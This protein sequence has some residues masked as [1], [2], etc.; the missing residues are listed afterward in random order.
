MK[1]LLKVVTLGMMLAASSTLAFASPLA[2]T[3]TINGATGAITPT[4]L[5][6]TTSSISFTV[7]DES[8][9]GYTGNVG[10]GLTSLLPPAYPVVEV[11]T[12]TSTFTIPNTAGTAFPGA[13]LFSYQSSGS[14]VAFTVTSV[15]VGA[16]GSLVFFGTLTGG[17]TASYVLTPVAPGGLGTTP[18]G[19]FT[20]TLTVP[21]VS[22]TPEPSSLILLGTG[23]VGAAGLMFR[24]RR[25]VKA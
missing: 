13:T 9:Y 7:N 12:F 8:T 24:K 16:N 19:S 5:S 3:I 25:A 18:D 22:P 23:L 11:V 4:Q 2:G 14:T 21:A 10:T 17:S 6:G 20:S 1:N 15:T